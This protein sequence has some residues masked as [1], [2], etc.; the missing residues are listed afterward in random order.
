MYEYEYFGSVRALKS[1]HLASR[2]ALFLVVPLTA[3]VL[4]L[5]KVMCYIAQNLGLLMH[6]GNGKMN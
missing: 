2:F 1:G 6:A 5:S 3:V 4:L